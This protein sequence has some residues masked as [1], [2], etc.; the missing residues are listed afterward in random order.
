MLI[1]EYTHNLDA[2]GRI[3]V[4]AKFRSELG[5]SAVLTRGLDKCLFLYPK[6]EWDQMAAKLASLPISSSASR[7]FS[8]MML[9]GAMEVEIDKQGRALL[10]GYLRE[11]AGISGQVVVTGAYNRAE[12]WDKGVWAAYSNDAAA[13]NEANAEKLADWQF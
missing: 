9:A 7:S 3:S 12:I 10:P 4:P 1:G 6:A 5:S 8:R 13:D 11:F 2:K